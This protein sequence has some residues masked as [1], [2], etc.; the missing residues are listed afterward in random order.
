MLRNYGVGDEEDKGSDERR[1]DVKTTMS[2]SEPERRGRQEPRGGFGARPRERRTKGR[3]TE[4]I[5]SPAYIAEHGLESLFA[6]SAR[7][8]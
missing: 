4:A 3:Y 7:A 8:A 1:G 6:T 2:C 5:Y